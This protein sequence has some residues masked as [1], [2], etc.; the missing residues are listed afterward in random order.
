MKQK[1]KKCKY[2]KSEFTPFYST[3]QAVCTPLCAALLAKGQQEKKAEKLQKEQK[4]QT[5][6][7]L[8]TNPEW[9]KL[10]ETEINT[11]V[12]L[13]DRDHPCMSSRFHIRKNQ[14]NAGHLY[15]VKSNPAIRFNL[16]NIYAQTIEQNQ[17]K[18]GAPLEFVEGLEHYFG[19][20]HKEYVLSLKYTYTV[21]K[22]ANHEIEEKITIA[23]GIVKWLKLQERMFTT[24]ERINLRH[25]FNEELGI[26]K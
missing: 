3:I 7:E 2:C 26:Y 19:K 14:V 17:H 22:L 1:T 9:L 20:H 18:G 15:S 5:K 13:I 25:R 16:F 11:I 21:L 23:K 10:L 8:R 24:E 12:R 6:K 4:Q